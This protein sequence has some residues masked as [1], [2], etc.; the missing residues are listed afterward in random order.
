M[1]LRQQERLSLEEAD[2]AGIARAEV[3]KLKARLTS[4]EVRA[5]DRESD[6]KDR[7]R[8]L[9]ERLV[10]LTE[11]DDV[12]FADHV[13]EAKRTSSISLPDEASQPGGAAARC[14]TLLVEVEHG[15]DTEFLFS[16]TW[17]SGTPLP[18]SFG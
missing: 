16:M 8:F 17:G 10:L 3:E 1:T 11:P 4:V 7:I 14:I 18:L 6:M 15:Y 5:A 12:M 2:R 13:E 9:E